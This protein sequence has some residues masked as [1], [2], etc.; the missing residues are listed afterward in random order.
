[1]MVDRKCYDIAASE[2]NPLDYATARRDSGFLVYLRTAIDEKTAL[3]TYQPIVASRRSQGAVFYEGLMRILDPT[4]RIIPARDFVFLAEETELGR[5][6]D[7]TALY[8]DL[9]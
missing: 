4:G 1:M 3:L 7:C 6:I 8:L 5:Q 9:T 2:D